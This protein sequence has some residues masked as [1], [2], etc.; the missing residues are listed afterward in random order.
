[1]S[2][3]EVIQ[4][5]TL[6]FNDLRKEPTGIGSFA[7]ANTQRYDVAYQHRVNIR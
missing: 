3:V 1:M 7:S 6:L 2:K 5:I 4:K